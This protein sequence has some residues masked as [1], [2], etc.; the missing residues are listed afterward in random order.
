MRRNHKH[1]S[2]PLFP[3]DENGEEVESAA[4]LADPHQSVQDAVEQKELSTELSRLLD[5]L[6]AAYR[7]VI[8][9]VDVHEL[10]YAEAAQVLDVPIGT[11]KSRLARA[12]LQMQKKLQSAVRFQKCAPGIP[13]CLA[14]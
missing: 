1:P 9:L 10:D 2:Q 13:D 14:A 5:R 4:W 8:L 7:E 6:P 3:E 11:V 12:R